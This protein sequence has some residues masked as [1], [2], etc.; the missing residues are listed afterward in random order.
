MPGVF[1]MSINKAI[2]LALCLMPA[3]CHASFPCKNGIAHEGYSTTKVRGICGSPM[4]EHYNGRQQAWL[5]NPGYGK[6]Y[7]TLIFVDNILVSIKTGSRVEETQSHTN[8]SKDEDHT[9]CCS[10]HKGICG[11]SG[12]KVKCCDG[13]FSSTCTY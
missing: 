9:G 4:E 2:F 6:F 12:N 11:Y 13:T 8:K 3:L 10:H 5:Y 1:P 7:K